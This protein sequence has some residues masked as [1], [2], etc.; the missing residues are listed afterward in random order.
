MRGSL[1]DR[2]G[3]GRVVRTSNQYVPIDPKPEPNR[4]KASKS[5]M[6][7][8]TGAGHFVPGR[9]GMII[10]PQGLNP[11]APAYDCQKRDMS[12]PIVGDCG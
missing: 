12:H 10:R 11:H 2:R 4:P 6:T 8:G 7:T 1:W 9:T 5:E 3:P